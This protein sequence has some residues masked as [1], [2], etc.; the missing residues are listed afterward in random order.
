MIPCFVLSWIVAAVC[1]NHLAAALAS[2]K[3]RC[4]DVA[5]SVS[6]A[7]PIHFWSAQW[8]RLYPPSSYTFGNCCTNRP[9][10]DSRAFRRIWSID[11]NGLSIVYTLCARSDTFYMVASALLYTIDI[12]LNGF[13]YHWCYESNNLSVDTYSAQSQL[14]Y[15]H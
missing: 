14:C 8:P 13:C 6:R 10:L 11:W 12:I 5:A 7:A 4:H 9:S 1:S 15:T 3:H 2:P